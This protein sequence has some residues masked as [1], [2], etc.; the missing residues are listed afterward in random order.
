M[1]LSRLNGGRDENADN[2][3]LVQLDDLPPLMFIKT[4]PNS[5]GFVDVRTIEEK[6]KAHFEYI[7]REHPE[8]FVMPITIHPDVSGRPREL[9]S[10][11]LMFFFHYHQHFCRRRCRCRYLLLLSLSF[12]L[13][14]PT[15]V[16]MMLERFIEW[17]NT[18]KDVEWVPMKEIAEDFRKNNVAPKGARMPKGLE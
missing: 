9:G 4:A 5:H 16:L 1:L 14:Q 3:G 11:L 2:P 10:G 15:D 7:Y 8:G 17:V 12:P 6:W 18:H 13:T